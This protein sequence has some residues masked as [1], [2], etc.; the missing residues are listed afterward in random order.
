MDSSLEKKLIERVTAEARWLALKII[1]RER[2]EYLYNEG[3]ENNNNDL[4]SRG[5]ELLR[6]LEKMK[7]LEQPAT[8]KY[9]PP[10]QDGLDR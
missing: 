2:A 7:Y 10:P 8:P 3:C 5:S 6:L 9:E 4:K 1:V